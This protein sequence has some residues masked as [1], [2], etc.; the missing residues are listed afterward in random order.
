MR[1]NNPEATLFE[2]QEQEH[3]FSKLGNPLESFNELIDWERFRNKL[4]KIYLNKTKGKG[5]RSRMD[6]LMMFKVLILQQL[7]KLKSTSSNK[8]L[9]IQIHFIKKWL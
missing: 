3:L 8:Y 6:S 9:Y 2:S 4:N 1:T 7:Y 5:G